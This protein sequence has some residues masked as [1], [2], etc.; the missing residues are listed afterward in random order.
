MQRHRAADT[1]SENFEIPANRATVSQNLFTDIRLNKSENAATEHSFKYT[2]KQFSENLACNFIL[3]FQ[4]SISIFGLYVFQ[5]KSSNTFS[6]QHLLS[7]S[8]VK[9]V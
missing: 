1:R 4:K 9:K 7:Y 8:G 6:T 5:V 3:A 2:S